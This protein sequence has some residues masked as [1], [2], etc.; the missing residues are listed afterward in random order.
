MCQVNIFFNPISR[1][2]FPP[3]KRTISNIVLYVRLIQRVFLLT[4]LFGDNFSFAQHY[5]AANGSGEMELLNDIF[6][7]NSFLILNNFH[8]NLLHHF[9]TFKKIDFIKFIIQVKN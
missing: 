8:A 1:I 4:F 7:L 3:K 9:Q 6:L 5:Y 2:S